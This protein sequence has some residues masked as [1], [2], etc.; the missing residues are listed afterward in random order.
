MDSFRVGFERFC[1]VS[2][3]RW[4]SGEARVV[5]AMRSFAGFTEEAKQAIETHNW[6]VRDR[7][8]R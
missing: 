5:E 1:V 6:K 3:A 4:L 2:Q 7:E 8:G